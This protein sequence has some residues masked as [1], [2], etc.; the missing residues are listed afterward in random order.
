[1]IPGQSVTVEPRRIVLSQLFVSP[2]VYNYALVSI[3]DISF[4]HVLHITTYST[5]SLFSPQEPLSQSTPHNSPL[6]SSSLIFQM[7]PV[8]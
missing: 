8:S 6:A 2:E 5:K 1:M 7:I 3:I 4:F